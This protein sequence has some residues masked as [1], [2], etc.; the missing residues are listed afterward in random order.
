MC[1]IHR[2]VGEKYPDDLLLLAK[3]WSAPDNG[4]F[5]NPWGHG[6]GVVNDSKA[7][8]IML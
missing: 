4:H 1:S 7:M 8:Q 2:T 5:T 6:R 3:F